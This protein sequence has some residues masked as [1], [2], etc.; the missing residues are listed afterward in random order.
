MAVGKPWILDAAKEIAATVD[1]VIDEDTIVE[2][3]EKHCPFKRDMAY[4]PLGS[5]PELTKKW[6]DE[7]RWD[8]DQSRADALE[9]C[10]SEVENLI[11]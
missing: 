3:I 11:N 9:S 8:M 6:R 10:A 1:G 2:I 7:A 4:A 5:I